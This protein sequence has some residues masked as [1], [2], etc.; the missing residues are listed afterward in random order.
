MQSMLPLRFLH[1]WSENTCMRPT[2]AILNLLLP[3]K[4]ASAERAN[5]ERVKSNSRI[6]I[7]RSSSA[8]S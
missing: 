7:L 3:P 6:P 5:W 2:R 1:V 4:I 8:M